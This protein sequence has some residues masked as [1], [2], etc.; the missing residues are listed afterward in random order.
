MRRRAVLLGALLPLLL[1]TIAGAQSL[2]SIPTDPAGARGSATLCY[3]AVAVEWQPCSAANPLVTTPAAGG[4]SDV[5]VQQWGG[6]NTT[7]GQKA[8]GGSVP[9][10]IASDQ[11]AVPENLTQV[12]GSAL[13]LGQKAMGSSIPVTWASDQ[14]A[15]L[16]TAAPGVVSGARAPWIRAF[17]SVCSGSADGRIAWLTDYEALAACAG[18]V[19]LS[20][21]R[22]HTWAA[23]SAPAGLGTVASMV[24]KPGTNVVLLGGTTS[25]GQGS[26]WRSNTGGRVFARLNL[27]ACAVST[28]TRV[29]LSG[30]TGVAHAGCG[31]FRSTDSGITWAQVQ[32]GNMGADIAGEALRLSDNLTWLMP[33]GAFQGLWRSTDDGLT[34]GAGF[35]TTVTKGPKLMQKIGDPT[36]VYLVDGGTSMRR[37]ID[38][39][40]TWSTYFTFDSAVQA[41]MQFPSGEMWVFLGAGRVMRSTD[42][43]LS[44]EDIGPTLTTNSCGSAT[45]MSNAVPNSF[46]DV[47][48]SD[49]QGG[50]INAVAY[51]PILLPGQTVLIDQAGIPMGVSANPAALAPVQ[52]A[53]LLNTSV[54]GA[55]NTAVTATLA[56]AAGVRGHVYGVSAFCSA[57][58]AT[59][60]ITDAAV[61]KWITPAGAVGTGIFSAAWPV[62][63]TGGTN[64]AVV[65]TLS[66]CGV[67]NTGTLSVQADRF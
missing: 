30:T 44:W 27:P 59:I 63:L 17:G 14:T 38:G 61:Q 52:G 13:T 57:G 37:S 41:G 40:A 7:L 15:T 2:T 55:A 32:V 28:T 50:G 9:T 24:V 22:G 54:T 19:Y 10:V 16:T 36:T 62:G 25:D 26:V 51:S 1:V 12:G 39:G 5:N 8:M 58:S 43:G 23:L 53:T 20:V 49:G 18:N 11:S 34:W 35:V 48:L 64:A 6:T 46:G 31:R 65:V 33:N 60:T 4:P 66:T 45:C 42:N 29:G 67:G 3:N 47:I 56:A 21:D